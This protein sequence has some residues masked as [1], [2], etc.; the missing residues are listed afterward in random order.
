MKIAVGDVS[1][2]VEE[3][4][5][6]SAPPLLLIM[7][8]GSQLVHWPD[9]FCELLV[10][11]GYRVV[12]FDNRDVGL[13]SSMARCGTPSVPSNALRS[14]C[15][16]PV[17]APY[18]LTDMAHDALGVLDALSIERAHVVG[19]SMGGM[20]AQTL[21]LLAPE[22]VRTLTSLMSSPRAI[23]FPKPAALL[24]LVEPPGV[25]REAGVRR[26]L[27]V[28][29]TLRGP[30]FHFDPELHRALAERV[31]DRAP[32]HPGGCP[33]QLSAILASGSRVRALRGL[34]LPTLVVHGSADPLIP[35]S[36]GKATARAIPA[37]RF[38][39]I[40]GLGH[41]L[42]PGVWPELVE[43]VVEHLRR[44]QQLAA[45][46]QARGASLPQPAPAC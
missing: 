22:R 18:T 12:R 14:L 35:I 16:L 3:L 32:A 8:L 17:D 9:P 4:G 13:S 41:H 34:R 44:P 1:L 15:G 42:P 27:E 29:E 38:H 43:T 28:F 19:I 31:Y 7:G 6:P 33:R 37:A 40:E 24:K 46:A 20:I 10:D 26:S 45:G 21:A 39:R 30:R 25:G 5:S 2:E 36:A 23:F 11:A